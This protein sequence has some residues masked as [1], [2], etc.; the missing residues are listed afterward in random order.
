MGFRDAD[1]WRVSSCRNREFRRSYCGNSDVGER[2]KTR[3]ISFYIV[4]CKYIYI[5]MKQ[6]ES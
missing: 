2:K 5:Y 4:I 1:R 3:F 6:F